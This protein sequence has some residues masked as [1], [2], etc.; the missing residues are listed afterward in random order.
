MKIRC[1]DLDAEHLEPSKAATALAEQ[2]GSLMGLGS[3]AAESE[4][5]VRE[6]TQVARLARSPVQVLKPLRLQ[7]SSRGSLSNLRPVAQTLR[8]KPGPG[9]ARQV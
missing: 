4:L 5:A 1:L 6:Q 3:G 8:P 7:M 2:C 9:Q